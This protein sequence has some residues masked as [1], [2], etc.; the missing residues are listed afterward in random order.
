MR[1][2]KRWARLFNRLINVFVFCC[3]GDESYNG[4]FYLKNCVVE[5]AIDL[6]KL[7]NDLLEDK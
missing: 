7:E 3:E 4:M 6:E 5:P 1:N 2:C